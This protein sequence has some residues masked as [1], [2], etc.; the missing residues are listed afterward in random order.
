MT[1]AA[2]PRWTW[3]WPAAAFATLAALALAGSGAVLSAIAGVTLFGT[4]F[5]AVYHAEVVAHRVGEPFGTLVLALAVT[6]IEAALIVS[7]MIAAPA[8]KAGLPR[9][10][11][12][13]A[14]MIVCNGIVGACLLMGGA[15]HREQGFQLQGASAALAVL[16][17]LSGL[18]LVLPN[19]AEG[20]LGPRFNTS[21]MVFAGIVSLVLYCSFVFIQT[22]RH[23]ACDRFLTGFR[24]Y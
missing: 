4:V 1:T 2:A 20:A 22:I 24:V 13:A 5:A 17:A 14:I 6:V 7:V 18:T 15:R 8:E 23:K 10:T 21:Q 16:V 12:F 9:D 11:V 19:Y 3:I